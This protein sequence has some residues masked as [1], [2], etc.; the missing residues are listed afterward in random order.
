MISIKSARLLAPTFCALLF[1][2][3]PSLYA[4]DEIT[5]TTY[6]PT[7]NGTYRELSVSNRMAIG[8]VDASADGK[9]DV[10]DMAVYGSND[11]GTQDD[12]I[13]GSLTIA[14]RLGIGTKTPNNLLQINDLITFGNTTSK[15]TLLGFNAGHTGVYLNRKN[16]TLEGIK[17][18]KFRNQALKKR[19]ALLE[20]QILG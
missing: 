9:V 8:N 12:P 13:L 17:E 7:P 18:L 14:S 6:Y 10:N 11:V 1:L 3:A 5:I 19:L 15:E 16:N 2:I 4:A 20:E